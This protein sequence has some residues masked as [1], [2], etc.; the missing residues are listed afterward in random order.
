[1]AYNKNYYEDR[2]KELTEEF[3][4]NI[5][6]AYMKVQQIV[7]E[8]TQDN[9]EIQKKFQEIVK[10]EEESKKADETKKSK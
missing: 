9:N 2:K 4:K 3:N 10:Q 7:L 8:Q 5:T 1:M 6:R